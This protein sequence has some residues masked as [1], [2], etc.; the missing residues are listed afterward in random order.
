MALIVKLFINEREIA[1]YAAVR[2]RGQPHEYCTYEIDGCESI[3][4]H[5]DDG[6]ESLAAKVLLC[7]LVK[8]S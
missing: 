2:K 3:D 6:A 5:Y 4:H 1:A 7:K 8:K